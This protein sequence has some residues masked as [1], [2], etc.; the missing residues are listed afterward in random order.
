MII[1]VIYYPH[2]E[3]FSNTRSLVY[4]NKQVTFLWIIS[5]LC[6][7]WNDSPFY[8]IIYFI[9]NQ[10]CQ[11]ELNS[12]ESERCWDHLLFYFETVIWNENSF[13]NDLLIQLL[14]MKCYY[15]LWDH[16]SKHYLSHCISNNFTKKKTDP[17]SLILKDSRVSSTMAAH[18]SR[19][20]NCLQAILLD[21]EKYDEFYSHCFWN[22]GDTR[23]RN[24]RREKKRA[25]AT[26]KFYFHD[27]HRS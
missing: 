18:F 10:I 16:Y 2:Y 23:K 4:L 1:Q 14:F 25:T 8:F 24:Y 7:E 17:S 3:L 19:T 21:P 20:N 13:Q 15:H 22:A 5:L 12:S 11:L 26:D 27:V 6:N 9:I